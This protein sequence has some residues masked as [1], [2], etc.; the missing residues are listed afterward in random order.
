MSQHKV[1]VSW[2]R[3]TADFSYMTYNRDHRWTFEGG[4]VVE[5]SAAPAYKGSPD[6]V[7]PEEAFVASLSSCH[8]LTFLA[9]CTKKRLVVDRYVDNAE[10]TMEKGADGRL[11]VTR[12]V[13]RP[14]ITFGEG[15]PSADVLDELHH[16]AHE[17]CFIANSVKT[18]VAVEAPAPVGE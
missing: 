14:E 12:V 3:E 15:P 5:A 1:T 18:D 10:G 7:D 4:S 13:L 6:H 8:M 17:Q 11:A 16:D 2:R 9:L